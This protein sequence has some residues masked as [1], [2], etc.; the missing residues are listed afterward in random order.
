MAV[1]RQAIAAR[2]AVVA[3]AAMMSCTAGPTA[4]HHGGSARTGA[5]LV[6]VGRG[7][8]EGR[9]WKVTVDPGDG[10]VCAGEAGLSRACSGLR[11]LQR[12]PGLAVLSGAD[13]AVS[14]RQSWV[15][16]GPP[17]W[18][19]LFGTVR[20]DVT[21]LVMRMSDGRQ[22][23]LKPVA[24]AGRKWVGLMLNPVRPGVAK[25]IAYS[26]R[27]ELGYSVPFYGGELRPGT[28][29]VG[30]LR[31]GQ[32]GPAY[33]ERY[34][35]SGGSDG[36]GWDSLVIAGSWGY[37]TSL[38]TPLAN[39]SRQD[40]WSAAALRGGAAV[41]MRIGSPA[42]VPRWIIGTA[43]PTVAYLRLTVP[44]HATIKVPV[45]AVSGQKFYAA[46]IGARIIRWDAFNA[47]GREL[48][49]GNG[50]PDA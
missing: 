16:N 29:F 40:C 10:L 23:S 41:I 31:P 20:P 28:Y 14:L 27:T 21:L 46:R 9:A 11:A 2:L 13:V 1:G 35:A 50:P 45:T 36:N 6:V 26:G 19:A 47:A 3:A 37:C 22:V 32:Q 42:T 15:S 33:A 43:R 25:A 49:G 34:I 24:A 44:G 4:S 18:D 17:V 38:D 5:R 8:I 30:W 39:G 48:Y 7:W 12:G